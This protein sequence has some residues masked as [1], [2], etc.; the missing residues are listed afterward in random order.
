MNPRRFLSH[1]CESFVK[2]DPIGGVSFAIATTSSLCTSYIEIHVYM[3][4]RERERERERVAASTFDRLIENRRASET[5]RPAE[6]NIIGYTERRPVAIREN[7]NNCT[8]AQTRCM[9]TYRSVRNLKYVFNN[10]NNNNMPLRARF[11]THRRPT[12][13]GRIQRR[14]AIGQD[15]CNR[16]STVDWPPVSAPTVL[17]SG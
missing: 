7:Y 15:V 9:R 5:I 3:Q 16:S 2:I 4:E 10:N 11:T 1:E 8:C 14:H 12:S 13:G 17:P 6:N